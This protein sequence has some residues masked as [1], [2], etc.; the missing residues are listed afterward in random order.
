MVSGKDVSHVRK[1]SGSVARIKP[2]SLCFDIVAGASCRCC[3]GTLTL[4]A[5]ATLWLTKER[6][7]TR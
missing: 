2:L 5:K 6:A 1:V 4:E 7:R 3:P